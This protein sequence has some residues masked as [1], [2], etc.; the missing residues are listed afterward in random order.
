MVALPRLRQAVLVAADLA[1]TEAAI[2]E[3]FGLAPAFHDPGVG[4]FG[5]ENAVFTVGDTFLEVVSPFREGTTA[6]RYRERTGGDGGYMAMFQLPSIAEGRQRVHNAGVRIVYDGAHPDIADIH[7]HPKDVGGAIMA[8]NE[9]RPAGSWRFGGEAWEAKVPDTIAPGQVN[10]LTVRCDDPGAMAARWAAMIGV[11]VGAANTLTLGGGTQRVAFISADGKPEGICGVG[12][13][14][15]ADVRAARDTVDLCGV[16]FT[17][18]N[19]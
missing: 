17:L 3:A 12:L 14:L 15:P 5:L 10:G 8:L 16:T 7:L 4:S 11:T 13:A 19:A 1:G 6:G 18:T 9:A 2:G